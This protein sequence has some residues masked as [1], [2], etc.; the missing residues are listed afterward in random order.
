MLSEKVNLRKERIK[1][2]NRINDQDKQ[3]KESQKYFFNESNNKKITTNISSV[4]IYSEN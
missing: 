1:G 4:S 3:Q 2:K